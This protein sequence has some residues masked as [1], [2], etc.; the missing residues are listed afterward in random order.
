M[1]WI[2]GPDYSNFHI[3]LL[4][5]LFFLQYNDTVDW[6]RGSKKYVPGTAC[7]NLLERCHDC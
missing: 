1:L 6:V 3:F 4:I 2:L 5:Q 7:K